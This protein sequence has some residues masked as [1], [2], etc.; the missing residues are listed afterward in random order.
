MKGRL[1]FWVAIGV[2]GAA[3]IACAHV[4]VR[5][6]A[7]RD[8]LGTI[9][10]RGHLLALVYDRGIYQGDVDRALRE[11]DY[12]RDI[13]RGDAAEIE[14]RAAANNLIANAAAKQP[15]LGEK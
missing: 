12:R 10:G 1:A 8:Q 6:I 14:R 7:L 2:A 13:E 11:F 15:A 9:C 3:G 4:A 5:S